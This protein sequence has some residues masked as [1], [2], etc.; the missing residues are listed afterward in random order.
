M[1]HFDEFLKFWPVII[2]LL[3]VVAMIAISFYRIGENASSIK[4]MKRYLFRDDGTLIYVPAASAKA[5]HDQIYCKL[6][7]VEESMKR[8]IT[9][10]EHETFCKIASFEMK[11]NFRITFDLFQDVLLKKMDD[12]QKPLLEKINQHTEEIIELK[13]ILKANNGRPDLML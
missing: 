4:D 8:F 7:G 9:D 5:Q 3:P 11:E 10:E 2:W 6:R 1:N 12:L 13:K